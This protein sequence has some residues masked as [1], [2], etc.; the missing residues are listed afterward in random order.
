VYLFYFIVIVVL[1]LGVANGQEPPR[2]VLVD[3]FGNLPC[4]DL[5][6]RL[7]LLAYAATEANSVGFVV[8]YPGKNVFENV[9]YER[10]I[11]NNSA[12]RR[13]PDGL[14]RVI[15]ATRKDELK[16]EMWRSSPDNPPV[17]QDVPFNYRLSD[18][19]RR[20]LF[21]DD[22]VEVFRFEGKLEY[23][24]DGCVNEFSLDVLSKILLTNP[25]LSAEIII[26][27]RSSREARKLS[28]L[29]VDAAIA[30]NKIPKDRL[31]VVYGGKGKAKEWSSSS[32]AVEVWLL[33]TR[34][35]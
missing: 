5:L 8:L 28:R 10:A 34:K 11:R 19:S 31:K 18:I 7:D 9:A 29:L 4:D 6:A 23:G 1:A 24:S 2:A 27:N 26:F 32:S 35:K 33:P 25:E 13:F 14:I 15:K 17:V 22:S 3:E 12:F 21:V 20:T 30:E 16:L